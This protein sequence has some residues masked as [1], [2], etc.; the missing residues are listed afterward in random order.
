MQ[1]QFSDPVY[2]HKNSLS[3]V[4]PD[5]E[6]ATGSYFA[7]RHMDCTSTPEILADTMTFTIEHPTSTISNFIVKKEFS[8]GDITLILVLGFIA[9]F[10]IFNCLRDVFQHREVSIHSIHK[11]VF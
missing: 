2:W 1:C 11:K 9:F 6:L 4:Y 10:V 8:Y 3:F 7:Y 5:A